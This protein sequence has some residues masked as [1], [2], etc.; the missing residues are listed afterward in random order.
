MCPGGVPGA[1]IGTAAG[2]H[3]REEETPSARLTA[4]GGASEGGTE[5]KPLKP[6]K[7]QDNV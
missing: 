5:S 2:V 1:T 4:G 3:A 7:P 6:I